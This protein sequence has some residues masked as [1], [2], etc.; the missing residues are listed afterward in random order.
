MTISTESYAPPSDGDVWDSL[1]PAQ[2]GF[3]AA[4]LAAAVDFA[5]AHE[6]SWPRSL[7]YPD[8]RYVGLVEWNESG[9]WSEIVGPVGERG[10]PAGLIVKG[11]RIVAEWGDTAR[12][13]MT[14]S[15]AKSY[16]AILAGLA[17]A[18]G[19]IGDVDEPV[20]K[21][22]AGP[23]FE[24]AHNR[25]ITWRHLLQQSSEWQG[26]IFGKSDQVDHNRQIGPGADNSRKGEKRALQPPGSYYEY[27]DVRVNLLAYC[28][29]QRFRRPLPEVLRER[30]M[31][32]IGASQ[33]W[34]WQGYD[35]AFVEIDG[36]RVQSVPGGGH[37]GGGLFI[38][39]R[40]H[41]RVGL[42]VARGGVWGGRELLSP[43]W[44]EAMLTP[45]PTLANYGYLWWLNRGAA[46]KPG[47]PTTAVFALGAGVNAIWLDPAQDLVAVLRW[48]DKTAL[49]GFVDRLI[50]AIR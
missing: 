43:A 33:G 29:L 1:P 12:T 39:A 35:N 23:W 22:V 48:I 31:D 8:G 44:I 14:F 16:I 7:Y 13:D 50:A 25:A 49:D 3:D 5:K 32:P 26:E 27:N 11:G 40:D 46:A 21:T 36:R 17:A 42:L 38:G 34:R 45:S 30:I 47:V 19:L 4:G 41:A 20:A 6:S 24:S 9:P 28:L 2:A 10:G 15:I 18:D 37:W